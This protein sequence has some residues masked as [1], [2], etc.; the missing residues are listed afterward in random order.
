MPFLLVRS[1]TIRWPTHSVGQPSSSTSD[2]LPAIIEVR[3]PNLTITPP[4][5][6]PT[7]QRE[8]DSYIKDVLEVP[9]S[10]VP[11]CP[12]DHF[13]L[14]FG[15]VLDPGESGLDQFN[16]SGTYDIYYYVKDIDTGDLSAQR[17]SRVYKADVGNTAPTAPTNLL[18]AAPADDQEVRP[19]GVDTHQR[20]PQLV[21][22]T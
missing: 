19:A 2:V 4:V 3:R 15:E 6:Q 10:G 14:N 13:C 7:L 12:A 1:V 11:D 5:G 16:D 17:L 8:A 22:G 20:Y 21:R 18:P 9:N